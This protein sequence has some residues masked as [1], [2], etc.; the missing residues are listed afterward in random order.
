[1]EGGREMETLPWR[2]SGLR[3]GRVR[4][5]AGRDHRLEGLLVLANPATLTAKALHL[6][7]L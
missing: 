1:M 5:T 7:I 4:G 2:G 3:Q 6:F